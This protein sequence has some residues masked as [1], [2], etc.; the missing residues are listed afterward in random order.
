MALNFRS[1]RSDGRTNAALELT[2]QV[3]VI[4][5]VDDD[6]V[7]SISEH[8]CG[9][10]GCRG[11]RT[12]VL[13]LRP[14]QPTK[15]IKFEKP[16]ESVTR[17]DLTAALASLSSAACTP[18]TQ[19]RTRRAHRI[20]PMSMPAEPVSNFYEGHAHDRHSSPDARHA[21]HRLSRLR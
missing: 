21:A 18:K 7:I 5:N 17:A 20:P 3:R 11:T 9:E 12:V 10:P 4:L 8:D 6:T 14:G 1:K 15:T 2:L 16:I 19:V 13:I